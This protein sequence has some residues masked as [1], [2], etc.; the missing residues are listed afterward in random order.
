MAQIPQV[1]GAEDTRIYTFLKPPIHCKFTTNL[2][3]AYL[4]TELQFLNHCSQ[5]IQKI[6]CKE[7]FYFNGG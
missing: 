2:T 4:I 1:I 3:K 5:T 7:I 6:S